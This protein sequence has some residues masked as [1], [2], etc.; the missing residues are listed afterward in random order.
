MG[1][2]RVVLR[3]IS[4][5]SSERVIGNVAMWK[6]GCFVEKKRDLDFTITPRDSVATPFTPFPQP[7][8]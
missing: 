5:S 6:V 3:A 7:R 4:N 8:G 2:R 1:S